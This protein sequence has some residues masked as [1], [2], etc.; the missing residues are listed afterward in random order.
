MLRILD[1][2]RR[3]ILNLMFFGL[4]LFLLLGMIVNLMA[5]SEELPDSFLLVLNPNGIVVE[6]GSGSPAEQAM[7]AALGFATEPEVRMR[8]LLHVLQAAAEDNRVAG[9]VLDLEDFWYAGPAQLEEL[10]AAMETFKASGKP[11][12]AF[13]YWYDQNGYYLASHADHVFLAEGGSVMLEGFAIYQNYFADALKSL[14]VDVHVFKAGEFKS[15]VEPYIRNDM[16]A[17]AKQANQ[18]LVDDLWAGFSR[19]V[20][21]Q[22][23]LVQAN[24]DDYIN[25]FVDAVVAAE[26]DASITAVAYGLVDKAANI[27]YADCIADAAVVQAAEQA[28]AECEVLLDPEADYE[29][30]AEL[31]N[32]LATMP[33]IEYSDYLFDL[34]LSAELDT[35]GKPQIGVI[36]ASGMIVDGYQPAGVIGSD[37]LI[38]LIEEAANDE[39][40]AA[41]VLRIDSPGGDALA[42]DDILLALD[43]LRAVKPVVVSM[44]TLAASGGY[45]IAMGGDEIYA[46]P[47]TITGSIGVFA[48]FP[49]LENSLSEL[50]IYTDGV[51]SHD[52]SGSFAIDRDFDPKV[53]AAFNSMI[54]HTYKSF[55]ELVAERRGMSVQEVDDVAQGRV[56]TGQQALENGL[57]DRLGG[58]QEA[59]ISAADWIKAD[60]YAVTYVEPELTFLDQ[61][62]MSMMQ[63]QGSAKAVELAGLPQSARVVQTQQ[64]LELADTLTQKQA[65]QAALQLLNTNRPL[66][67]HCMC[68]FERQSLLQR[69]R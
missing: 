22:R 15:A 14:K 33:R 48:M 35:L 2:I 65:V 55:L 57:V 62:A 31:N 17:A 25:G 10:G 8:D 63:G 16:S 24:L 1:I 41:V 42:S 50:G 23:Q 58:L 38:E 54:Q 12:V 3:V 68:D 19:P 6:Q 27:Y 20:A 13:G 7:D 56:W 67:S 66:V 30:F 26:G 11:I 36:V 60:D 29:D 4:L 44:G 45:W 51:G 37:S 59:I 18:A 32:K 64:W 69:Q 28:M 43:D 40:I 52:L 47:T 61:L 49:T 21:Q 9:V 5:S 46:Q 53:A 39:A 34:S